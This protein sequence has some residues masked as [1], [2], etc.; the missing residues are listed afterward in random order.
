MGREKH[1]LSTLLLV[2]RFY[3]PAINKRPIRSWEIK[4]AFHGGSSSAETDISI[5]AAAFEFQ[6]GMFVKLQESLGFSISSVSFGGRKI[7]MLY[8]V[9]KNVSLFIIPRD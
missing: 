8:T 5:P 1:Q 4:P 9:L 3:M 2:T 6:S 7:L